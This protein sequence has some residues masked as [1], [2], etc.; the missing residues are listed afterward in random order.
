MG[1]AKLACVQG[2]ASKRTQCVYEGVAGITWQRETPAIGRV[3]QQRITN[4]RHVNANLVRTPRL[5]PATHMGMGTIA[6]DHT[7]MRDRLAAG[8]AYRHALAI[9]RM[10]VDR[11]IDMPAC[12]HHA[13]GHRLVFALDRALGQI[14]DQFRVRGKGLG[15]HENAGGVLVEPMHDARPRQ[16]GQRCVVVDQ[17]I[18]QRAIRVAGAGMHHEPGRFVDHQNGVVLVDDIE[19]DRLGDHAGIVRLAGHEQAYLLAAGDLGLGHRRFAVDRERALGEPVLQART[20]VV[21]QHFSQSPIQPPAGE[22]VWNRRFK[23]GVAAACRHGFSLRW[24]RG[25]ARQSRGDRK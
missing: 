2:L 24:Q 8:V 19:R 13:H 17:R 16:R 21:G 4:M 7:I 25:C 11:R 14:R 15:H 1:Q 18:L 3:A 5:Q 23:I 12:G 10:A 22:L 9:H 6:R 20:R